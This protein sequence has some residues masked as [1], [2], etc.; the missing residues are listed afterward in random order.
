MVLRITTNYGNIDYD[1]I[2]FDDISTEAADFFKKVKEIAELFFSDEINLHDFDEKHIIDEIIEDVIAKNKFE[3][4]MKAMALSQHTNSDLISITEEDD[5]IFEVN[6]DEYFVLT[7]DEA[8]EKALDYQLDLLEDVGI[9]GLEKHIYVDYI[10][11]DWFDTAMHESHESYAWE[12]KEESAEYDEYINRLHEEMVEYG[13]MDEPEWPDE[14]D[15][16]Y[17]REEF[18]EEEP[19]RDNFNSENDWE[20]AYANWE[21]RKSNFEEEQDRLEEQAKEAYEIVKDEYKRK[22]EDDIENNIEK[23]IEELN[24]NYE[25]GI[26]YWEHNFGSDEVVEIAKRYNLID[27]DGLARYLIETDGRGNV[28]NHYDGEEYEETVKFKGEE[29]TYFIYQQ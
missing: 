3:N 15:Y 14:D 26:E 19:V 10:A 8:N 1:D 29:E 18:D 23:F 20:N 12:I 22:L 4:P 17:E 13:V 6:G 5:E 9:E 11:S 28:L 27:Y 7:D 25:D 24:S 21:E 16:K 2:D